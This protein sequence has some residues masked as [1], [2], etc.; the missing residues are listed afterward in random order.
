MGHPEVAEVCVVG[1]PEADWGE[2]VAAVVVREPG[3][4][5]TAPAL[6]RRC[7]DRIAR[8]KKPKRHIFVEAP[9]KTSYGKVGKRGVLRSLSEIEEST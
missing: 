3:S 1:L 6:E 2:L 8:F 7:L 9:P 4:L 5:V